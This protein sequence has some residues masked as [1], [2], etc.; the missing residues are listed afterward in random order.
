[1]T[2]LVGFVHQYG[3]DDFSMWN[4]QLSE[5][6][7]EAIH[8]ILAKYEANGYSIRGNSQMKLKEGF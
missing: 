1:M 8:K 3:E 4:V 5:E 2:K 7:E 6:D